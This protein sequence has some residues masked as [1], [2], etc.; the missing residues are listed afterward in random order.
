MRDKSAP[1][2]L[3]ELDKKTIETLGYETPRKNNISLETREGRPIEIPSFLEEAVY[4][5]PLDIDE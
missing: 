1:L 2:R 4:D 3:P 5:G